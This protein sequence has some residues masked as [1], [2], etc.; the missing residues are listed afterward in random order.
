MP[1]THSGVISAFARRIVGEGGLD[2]EIG[3]GLRRLYDDRAYVDYRLGEPAAEESSAA[4]QD[5]QRLLDAT[6]RWIDVRSAAA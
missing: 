4:I 2:H 6:V 1:H 3:R 5:A